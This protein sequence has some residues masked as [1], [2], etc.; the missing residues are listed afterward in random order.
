MNASDCS[1][2]HIAM[3]GLRVDGILIKL[4]SITLIIGK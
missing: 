4:Y 2:R 1:G 3:F